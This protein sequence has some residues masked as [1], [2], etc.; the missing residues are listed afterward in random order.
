MS[1]GGEARGGQTSEPAHACAAVTFPVTN[2]PAR[3]GAG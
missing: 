1:G 2:E 3:D